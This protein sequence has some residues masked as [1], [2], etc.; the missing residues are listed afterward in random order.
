M[1]IAPRRVSLSLFYFALFFSAATNRRRH[2][3]RSRLLKLFAFYY[4]LEQNN[5]PSVIVIRSKVTL[6]F[7]TWFF[8]L[9][10]RDMVGRPTPSRRDSVRYSSLEFSLHLFLAQRRRPTSVGVS[11]CERFS[12]LCVSFDQL[13][14]LP[15]RKS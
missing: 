9:S 2:L 7:V 3:F 1:A 6:R 14:P 12:L 8:C 5:N 13:L 15:C 11:V 10:S 4:F